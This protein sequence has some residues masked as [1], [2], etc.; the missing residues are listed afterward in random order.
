MN[1]IIIKIIALIAMLL[2]HIGVILVESWGLFPSVVF[3]AL[4]EIGRVSFPL[5]AFTIANGWVYTK[6]K[7]RYF[8]RM[9][10][11]AIISQ[12]P[13]SLAFYPTNTM[14]FEPN[15][16]FLLTW[17]VQIIFQFII[18]SSL[19]LCFFY[20]CISHSRKIMVW[21]AIALLIAMTV[22]QIQSVC[23]IGDYLNIFYT[24]CVAILFLYCYDIIRERTYKKAY[25]YVLMLEVLL[26][27]PLL[28]GL[29][30]DYGKFLTGPLLILLLYILRKY[31]FLQALT[32]IFWG[33]FLYG[34][35]I[36]NWLNAYAVIPAGIIILFYNN[37]ELKGE[38][39]KKFFY[40]FYPMH[41]LLLGIFNIIM[42]FNLFGK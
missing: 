2:D 24:F 29:K 36:G 25:K 11:F 21:I 18:V 13:Y 5:F 41:L 31:K 20:F 7:E 19:C 15:H 16:N 38:K 42:K 1:I 22:L 12:I 28:V 3:S 10:L 17:N 14:R 9:L 4:R 26:V 27:I 34:I 39:V 35:V 8:G 32:I 37:E 40:L 23:I 33:I 30:A 6:N